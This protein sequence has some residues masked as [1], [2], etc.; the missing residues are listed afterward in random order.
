MR[1]MLCDVSLFCGREVS[2]Q[3][4]DKESVP[5]M[6]RIRVKKTVHLHDHAIIS[7]I[8]NDYSFSEMAFKYSYRLASQR[9]DAAFNNPW[10]RIGMP[11]DCVD[12]FVSKR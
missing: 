7:V 3:L 12:S 1:K 4:E 9:Y 5:E 11:I 2:R 10:M 6:P 8:D